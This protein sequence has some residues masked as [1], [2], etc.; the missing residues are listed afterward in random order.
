MTAEFFTSI[1]SMDPAMIA[2][3]LVE[4]GLLG[5]EQWQVRIAAVDA[6]GASN[7]GR[8]VEPLRR[9]LRDRHEVVRGGAEAAIQRLSR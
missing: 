3:L 4:I 6:L 2:T 7:D 5:D 8:A 1:I 9:L